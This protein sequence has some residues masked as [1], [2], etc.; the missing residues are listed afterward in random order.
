MAIFLQKAKHSKRIYA[1]LV[2]TKT[3]CDGHKEQ[4]ITFPSGQVQQNLLTEFYSDLGVD[5]G[6]IRYVEAHGTGTHVGDPEECSALDTVLCQN[7]K[8]ALL[9]GSVKSNMGHSESSSGVCSITKV[10]LALDR[11]EVPPNINY[12]T[13]HPGISSIAENRIKVCTEV[14]QLPE[15]ALVG[16]NSFGFGGG[17][18]HALL[19]GNRKAKEN[20]GWPNDDIPRLVNWSGRTE[21]T[22]SLMFDHLRS[23]PLDAEYIGLLHNIQSVE[24]SRFLNR[25]FGIFAKGQSNTEPAVCLRSGEQRYDGAKR[26]MIWIFSGIGSQ[27]NEMGSSMM[28]LP[29]FKESIDKSHLILKPYGIDLLR[30]I[31]DPDI[32]IFENVINSVVGIAAIQIA[33]VDVLRELNIQPDYIIGHS[34]GELGCAYA[35][36]ALTQEQT[37]L[38]AYYRGVACDSVSSARGSM[39]AVGM[40]HG[41]LKQM[42]PADIDVACHNSAVSTTISGPEKSIETFVDHLSSQNIFA[43]VVNSSN[44]AFHSRYIVAIGRKLLELTKGLFASVERSDKW[45]STSVP[46]SEWDKPQNRVCNAEYFVNNLLSSVLFEETCALLPANGIAVEIAPHGLMQAIV[47]RSM[48]TTIHIPL[49]QRGNSKNVELFLTALGK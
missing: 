15:N 25:G 18:A 4:G 34:V 13:I 26:P 27:W 45:L 3:N 29:L 46:Q 19:R 31:T 6:S 39:A 14:T 28:V 16:I 17:N 8:E 1:N 5:T 44:I 43:R 23:A 33:F 30:I 9:V 22:I 37:M 40:A 41:D 12:D 20:G 48:P 7:R 42:L 38:L 11:G 49:A 10:A 36:G 35:D 24:E 47:K 2:Y 32:R 21:E